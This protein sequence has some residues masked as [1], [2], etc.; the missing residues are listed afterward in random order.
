MK[1]HS[2]KPRRRQ[3]RK[4]FTLIELLGVIAIISLLAALL[5]PALKNAKETANR[6]GC[7][8]NLRQIWIAMNLYA[9]D[10]SKGEIQL[11]IYYNT[12][13]GWYGTFGMANNPL[14]SFIYAR[15]LTV[16]GYLKDSKVFYCPTQKSGGVYSYLAHTWAQGEW[17][18][19]GFTISSPSNPQGPVG[20]TSSIYGTV[21][22]L[23][24]ATERDALVFELSPVAPNGSPS[25]SNFAPSA[26]HG[27]LYDPQVLHVLWGDGGVTACPKKLITD[28]M[29]IYSPDVTFTR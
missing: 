16:P 14:E 9:D 26:H 10:D 24:E 7:I 27:P 1:F 23:K 29:Y 5:L 11:R 19:P 15:S 12:Q 8:N 2:Q 4:A 28:Y 3:A 25:G 20:S 13:G 21:R 6:A 17:S 18:T 22:Y